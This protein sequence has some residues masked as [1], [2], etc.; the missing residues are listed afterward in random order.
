MRLVMISLLLLVPLAACSSGDKGA[1]PAPSSQT[2]STT[3][4]A[5]PVVDQTSALH[6]AVQSYSDAY[7][8]GHGKAAYA[9]LSARCQTRYTAK[10]FGELVNQAGKMYGSALPMKSFDAEVSG[11]LA[12]V[13]YTYDVEA[14]NQDAEPWVNEGGK[15]HE[16][17]C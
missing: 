3:P 4:S 7:L 17:D 8:T 2:P 5:S 13:T 1:D 11:S 12:R 16:D 9:L 10:E 15:W 6:A 14:I